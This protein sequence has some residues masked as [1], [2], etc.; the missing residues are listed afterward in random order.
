MLAVAR[1]AGIMAIKNTGLIVPLAHGGVG[2]EGARVWVECVGGGGCGG[3]GEG[4]GVGEGASAP[5]TTTEYDETSTSTITPS[6]NP[7]NNPTPSD[8]PTDSTP[9][10][11][12]QNL[13]HPIPPHGGIRISAL[14]ETTGKTGVEMEALAG[15]VGAGL[16]VVDMVKGVDRGCVME[17]VRVVG[18][19]GGR[20]GGW[21]VWEEGGG[22]GKGGKGGGFNVADAAVFEGDGDL[23]W[24]CLGIVACLSCTGIE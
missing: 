24:R 5:P 18:K 8:N 4:E 23:D 7:P 10:L 14:V 22:G 1:V 16:T 15:V 2:V 11:R 12:A 3:E 9:L 6:D 13:T 17:G 21:G 20:R 19:R